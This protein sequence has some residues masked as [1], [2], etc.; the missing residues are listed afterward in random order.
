MKTMTLELRPRGLVTALRAVIVTHGH[1][2][3][4]GEERSAHARESSV[5]VEVQGFL[6]SRLSGSGGSYSGRPLART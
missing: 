5:R 3:L 2:H 6:H 1:H 4:S